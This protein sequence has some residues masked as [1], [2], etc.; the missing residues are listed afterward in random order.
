[1]FQ[2]SRGPYWLGLYLHQAHSDLINIGLI[3]NY[4]AHRSRVLDFDHADI[5]RL[6][7]KFILIRRIAHS[8]MLA[9]A[10]TGSPLPSLEA[11]STFVDSKQ[12]RWQYIW[13]VQIIIGLLMKQ[14]SQPPPLPP[15]PS[16]F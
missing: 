12:M 11:V 14:A 15:L 13:T 10:T 5:K 9:T 16:P 1:V 7:K 3:R 2:I 6:C 4:F 8:E